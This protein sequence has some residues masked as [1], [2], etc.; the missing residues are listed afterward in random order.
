MRISIV[1]DL[2]PLKLAAKADVDQQAGSVRQ[3]F[4]TTTPGQELVYQEKRREAESICLNPNIPTSEV[5][6]LARE[7]EASSVDLLTIASVDLTM[8]QQ[9]SHVSAV[10]EDIRLAAKTA[11]DA[12]ADPHEIETARAVDWSYFVNET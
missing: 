11:I 10:I 1:K 12:A 4:I 3:R 5:P 7:A 9:W 6:H 2:T 8:A